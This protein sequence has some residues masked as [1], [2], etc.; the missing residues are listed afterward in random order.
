ML[1]S[2]ALLILFH[3]QNN[4]ERLAYEELV[5]NQA[6][7]EEIVIQVQ[8]REGDTPAIRDLTLASQKATRPPSQRLFETTVTLVLTLGPE[9]SGA[10][11]RHRLYQAIKAKIEAHPATVVREVTGDAEVHTIHF[12]AIK[13]KGTLSI[14]VSEISRELSIIIAHE[15]AERLSGS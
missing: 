13:S 11:F 10:T 6:S 12:E 2:A 3:C 14:R 5:L 9:N 8:E 15:E 7:L 4:G 1:L